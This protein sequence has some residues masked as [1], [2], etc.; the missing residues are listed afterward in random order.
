MEA[1]PEQFVIADLLANAIEP[2]DSL[3]AKKLAALGARTDPDSPLAAPVV[4]AAYRNE[5]GPVLIDG[6][7]RLQWLAS[8][9]RNRTV[10][11]ADEVVV[12]ASAVDEESAHLAAVKLHV[13]RRPVP[14]RVKAELALR[15][16]SR[17]GWSQATIAEALKESRPAVANWIRQMGG[18]VPEVTGA[19]GKVYPARGKQAE[20][21]R[22]SAA[23]SVSD[24]LKALH[25]EHEAALRRYPSIRHV[26]IDRRGTADPNGWKITVPAESVR[27]AAEVADQLR[28]QADELLSLA[29]KL[30]QPP[31]TS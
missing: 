1:D 6:S 11:S 17:F 30:S 3:T 19:D 20:P 7:Q 24:A 9:P 2:W 25:T 16:Q 8:P 23:G 18:D 13:N 15:L 28:H 21:V 29:R 27:A 31:G 22:T 4:I 14:A 12:D 5:R 10:I 26:R